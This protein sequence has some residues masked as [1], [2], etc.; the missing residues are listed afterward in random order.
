M[1]DH[2]ASVLRRFRAHAALTQE[3]LA[4][5]SGVSVSTI[6][7]FETG[8]RG[9]PQLGTVRQLADALGL[10][11]AGHDE[12]MA[13]AVGVTASP[14]PVPRQLPA[15]PRWFT[16]RSAALAALD[17]ALC[18]PGTAVLS[19]GG[20]IGKSTLAVR[21]A[22]RNADRFP[23]GQLFVN[24]RGF[25]PSGSPAAPTTALQS[26]LHALGVDQEAFPPHLDAQ[27]SLFR[28]LTA[29]RRMLVVLDNAADAAQI[30]PL[31]PGGG[32]TTIVTSRHRLT[33]LV[34]THGAEPVLVDALPDD[35]ARALLGERVGADRVAAEPG[36]TEDLVAHCAGLP[37]A[38]S[39]VAGR[40]RARPAFALASFAAQLADAATRLGELDD[41]DSA[42]VRTV[43]SWST[44]A[45]TDEQARMF[46]LLG[47]APGP[48]VGVAS[49]AC[50]AD[51]TTQQAKTIL[52][53]LERVSLLQEHQPGRYRMYDLVRLHA[54]EL[55]VAP[56]EREASV[57]R[58]VTMH[59]HTAESIAGMFW[60]HRRPSLLGPVKP[61]A[62]THV[63]ATA[64]EA[65]SW[66][67]AERVCLRATVQA[68][69]D[70]GMHAEVWQ[71]ARQ[72]SPFLALGHHCSQIGLHEEA[73]RHLDASLAR[74]VDR[75]DVMQEAI[76]HNAMSIN[77]SLQDD[78]PSAIRHAKRSYELFRELGNEV[79]EAQSLSQFGWQTART[80]QYDKA[81][82]AC[83]AALRVFEAHD[84]K[85]SQAVV[86]HQLAVIARS[87]GRLTDARQ[88]HERECVLAG[89]SEV[90]AARRRPPRRWARCTPN[91]ATSRPPVRRGRTRSGCCANNS[92][93][94]RRNE[95]RSCCR[96]SPRDP[97]HEGNQN[98]ARSH[99]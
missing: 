60:P 55:V 15:P 44:S 59:A 76:V 94:S 33:A 77:S 93:S 46:A 21:W 79:F 7:G 58:L 13:S 88:L 62:H 54:A 14:A 51:L 73:Q 85:D 86:T 81:L 12:L 96:R 78:V 47:T 29:D 8:R 49:A 2:F 74:A 23:D 66:F 72:L 19:G 4:E 53:T 16:G 65:W 25:D 83:T 99:G 64:E 45:L 91:S 5:R 40:A 39:V 75:G 70:H 89:R 30:T 43:L 38:L 31:L 56:G 6:R 98:G 10:S 11:P 61:G 69:A 34:A 28:S 22:H 90:R 82:E 24:L 27:S 71:L 1:A 92:G 3:A 48:D 97:R 68:A 84:D 57:A 36:A 35:E 50:L 9:N 80:G 37:L 17:V 18:R 32:C 52:R 95:W 20:G 26:F 42:S 67:H 63:P 41:D 87:T